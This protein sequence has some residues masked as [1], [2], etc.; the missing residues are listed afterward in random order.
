MASHVTRFEPRD[1]SHVIVGHAPHRCWPVVEFDPL[2]CLAYSEDHRNRSLCVSECNDF[3]E[4]QPISPIDARLTPQRQVPSIQRQ[5]PLTLRPLAGR[6]LMAKNQSQA[7]NKMRAMGWEW[8]VETMLD[9]SGMSKIPPDK[10]HMF[11]PRDHGLA[12]PR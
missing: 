12:W 7:K 9:R 2:V 8:G 6:N 4:M 3:I 10:P 5:V 1:R 11:M